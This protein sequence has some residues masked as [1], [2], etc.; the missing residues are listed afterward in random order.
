MPQDP[1]V[2][3]HFR[4]YIRS[5]FRLTLLIETP[6]QPLSM[7][8]ENRKMLGGGRRSESVNPLIGAKKV[9]KVVAG[10][11]RFDPER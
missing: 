1:E 7:L 6:E 4:C 9:G 11:D 5:F 2:C 10:R 8:N 3:E